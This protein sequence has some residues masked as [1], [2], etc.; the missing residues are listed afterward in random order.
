[1]KKRRFD[2]ELLDTI[3]QRDE[4]TLLGEYE[5]YSHKI[6]ISFKCKC[7]NQHKK[8]F[9][10]G[11]Y[12]GFIC[13]ECV[14]KKQCELLEKGRSNENLEKRL[15][16]MKDPNRCSYYNRITL[17]KIIKDSNAILE[18]EYPELVNTSIIYFTCCCGKDNCNNKFSNIAGST[19]EDRKNPRGAFC[20][21]CIVKNMI[22]KRN[23]TN[24]KLYGKLGGINQENMK[25]KRIRTC[26]EKYGVE[27]SNQAESVKRKKE[28]SS[29]K[30]FGVPNPAQ[31][32]E[33]MEKTQKNAKKFKPF[34]MPSGEIR[35]VQGYE[36][37]ALKELINIYTED[38]IK[39]ERIN[40]P[41]IQY[42]INGKKRYHFPDIFIPHE[43]KIIEVKS[44]WTYKCKED[45][46]LLKKKTCE[47]Q[48]YKYEIWCF[49][50]K[51]NKQVY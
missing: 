35:K 3:L 8:T 27:S 45:N 19:I 18:R 28:E 38:Q 37:F 49:D 17:D 5:K 13:K 11:F 34:I 9:T 33:I 21:E 29:I 48:G 32:Q 25:E 22:L 7:D 26:I 10:A 23:E 43:N 30:K 40:V 36:P 6:E 47:D 39:T 24:M 16:T 51:G 31:S 46:V 41:R 44:S 15:K 1:M 4:A 14:Y 50:S 2:K 42:E 20:D 12:H